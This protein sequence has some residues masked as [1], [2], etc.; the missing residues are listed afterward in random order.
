MA[1]SFYD[2]IIVVTKGCRRRDD[3]ARE[4]TGLRVGGTR[5]WVAQSGWMVAALQ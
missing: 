4:G 2:L 5:L 1:Q 3:K